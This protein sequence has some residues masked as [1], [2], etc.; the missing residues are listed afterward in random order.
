MDN[1]SRDNLKERIRNAPGNDIVSVISEH[2]DLQRKGSTY[3]GL[4]P[5]HPDTHPSMSVNPNMQIFKCFACGAGGDVF[6]FLQMRE[7]LTFPQALERLGLRAGI[8]VNFR[9]KREPRTAASDPNMLLRV[10]NWAQ[11]YFRQKFLDKTLGE[12]AREYCRQRELGDELIEQWGLG[13]CPDSWDDMSKAAMKAGISENLLIESGISVK[14]KNGT[15][16]DN[17][18]HRLIFPIIDTMGNYI[19]FGGRTLGDDKRKYVNSPANAIFDKSNCV[20]GLD[21]ARHAVVRDKFAVLVEG[22]TDVIMSHHFGFDN[23]VAALGTSVTDGQIR[24]IKRFAGQV[25]MLLDS[26]IA[27][28]AAADRALSVCIRQ[29]VDV[30]AAFVPDGKD[31][32]EFLLS[33]GED[34]M[35]DVIDGAVDVFDFKWRHLKEEIEADGST[36]EKHSSTVDFL[37]FVAE[38]L[39]AG[40]IDDISRGLLVRRLAGLTGMSVEQINT[41]LER[42]SGNAGRNMVQASENRQVKSFKP[43]NSAMEKAVWEIVEVII[44]APSNIDSIREY[45]EPGKLDDIYLKEVTAALLKLYDAKGCDFTLADLLA[46]IEET[47]LAS[48][49]VKLADEGE[50]KQFYTE[51]IHSAVELI[52]Y[53][54]KAEAIKSAQA[55]DSDQFMQAIKE[56]KDLHKSNGKNLR[57]DTLDKW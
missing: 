57:L 17:Y 49:L 26:D 3:V 55:S 20:Y 46:E 7:N 50:K 47:E 6:K 22:Y 54:R 31:P 35:R 10:N 29:G 23:V 42:L 51:R 15:L 9:P 36:V 56:L 40:S 38:A 16:M 39:A 44:N 14:T 1:L 37:R 13:Y 32:C 30:K 11:R 45:I 34:A 12:T 2:L 43:G 18:K 28:R 24:L 8:E 21:K 25:V 33:A 53:N 41:R 4:C 27:G 48:F 52:K 19:G 5:F